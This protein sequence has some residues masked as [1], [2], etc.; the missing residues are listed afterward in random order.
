MNILVMNVGSSSIKYSVFANE[1]KLFGGKLERIYHAKDYE[2][3]IRVIIGILEKRK[4][5]LDV[6]GHRTVLAGDLVGPCRLTPKVIGLLERYAEFVPL[7]N[8]PEIKAIKVCKKLFKGV[9]QVGVFDTAF[10]YGMP[11][12]AIVY[13][14][15]YSLYAKDG[16]KR[17][18]YHGSSHKFVAHE[19]AKILEKPFRSLKMITCHL[20]SGCSMTA[21][22]RGKVV[23]TSMGF[24]PL[25]GLVMSTRSGDIDP[26]L[27]LYLLKHKKMSVQQVDDLLNHKSGLYGISGGKRDIRDLTKSKDKRSQLALEIFIYRIVKYLGGYIAALNGVDGIVFTGGI[28]EHVPLV[29]ERVLAHFTHLGISIEKKANKKNA[30]IISQKNSNIKIM[31][32]PTNEELQIARETISFLK[33]G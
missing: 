12:K 20:G 28:G 3:A 25:E 29:R 21:I 19:A 33:K 24:T 10:S 9:P 27:V 18:G 14:L 15:P 31:V 1:K 11:E 5:R 7:H 13:P 16:I 6:V 32:I 30:K 2:R 23:D 26:S 17:Y 4:I 22:D 8:H